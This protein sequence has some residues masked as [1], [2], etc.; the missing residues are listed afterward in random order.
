MCSGTAQMMLLCTRPPPLDHC[1]WH[2]SLSLNEDL[3]HALLPLTMETDSGMSGYSSERT[4][5]AQV[6]EQM[7]LSQMKINQN[8]CLLSDNPNWG[9]CPQ[10]VRM[11]RHP[12][13]L[14]F[15]L[16][17]R[18]TKVQEGPLTSSQVEPPLS[19]SRLWDVWQG[20][21]FVDIHPC[22]P[23]PDAHVLFPTENALITQSRLM[24]LESVLIFFNLLAVLSYLKFSNSQKHRYGE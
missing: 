23:T 24:L 14:V 6:C 10:S 7:K 13:E 9:P 20:P 4:L 16:Q 19:T 21:F 8:S 15:L 18:K 11:S 5:S 17:K 1:P 12:A 2:P 22:S 3:P